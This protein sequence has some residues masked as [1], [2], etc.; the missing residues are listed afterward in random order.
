MSCRLYLDKLIIINQLWIF[1]F[2]KQEKERIAAEKIA[3]A[4]KVSTLSVCL[5]PI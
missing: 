2:H 4:S 1:C 3:K 5:L